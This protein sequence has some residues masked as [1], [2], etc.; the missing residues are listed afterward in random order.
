MLYYFLQIFFEA[1]LSGFVV[2]K[3]HNYGPT[4]LELSEHGQAL[5][6]QLVLIV[7]DQAETFFKNKFK[8]LRLGQIKVAQDLNKII[9]LAKNY[10]SVSHCT[11]IIA[12]ILAVDWHLL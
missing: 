12:E 10:Y 5:G 4:L 8:G 6:R 2:Q 11:W 3:R 7:M 9:S 1:F